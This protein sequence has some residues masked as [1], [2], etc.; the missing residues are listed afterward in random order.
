M[1]FFDADIFTDAFLADDT[2]TDVF[3]ETETFSNNFTIVFLL[4]I[5]DVL[6]F[7][8][9]FLMKMFFFLESVFFDC[10]TEEL[11]TD[12]RNNKILSSEDEMR[13]LSNKVEEN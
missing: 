6:C 2:F 4:V 8:A 1:I 7:T 11:E 10:K 5:L 3:L 13:S 12:D 9:A